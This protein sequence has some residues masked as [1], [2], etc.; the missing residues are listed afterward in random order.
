MTCHTQ[1]EVIQYGE[2]SAAREALGRL[3]ES[4]LPCLFAQLLGM[5]LG[6][7]E[8]KEALGDFLADRLARIEIYRTFTTR[9]GR[10]RSWLHTV[11]RNYVCNRLTS[12]K[13]Q[14]NDPGVLYDVDDGPDA[15]GD[16]AD[17]SDLV[18]ALEILHRAGQLMRQRC[19]G[20]SRERTWRVLEATFLRSGGGQMTRGE[21]IE[22]SGELGITV[23][24]LS[25]ART[26]ARRM[27]ADCLRDVVRQYEPEEGVD[28]ELTE[29][30][31]VLRQ[32]PEWIEK[33]RREMRLDED[34]P[35]SADPFVRLG[36]TDLRSLLDPRWR[37]GEVLTAEELR[38]VLT[39]FLQI[40]FQMD[41]RDLPAEERARAR[42]VNESADPPART[43]RA[44]LLH[45][46]PPLVSLRLIKEY[47][48]AQRLHPA[49]GI[50]PEI[51]D[52]L[53]LAAVS[54][55]LARHGTSIS[56]A[57]VGDLRI[58]LRKA[59]ASDWLDE[60]VRGLLVD[61]LQCLSASDEGG[62]AS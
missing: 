53:Y 38:S 54:A 36:P 19:I 31:A 6:R 55:A 29:L 13:L 44:V 45:A 16:E 12:A 9:Q 47:F 56:S 22:A 11:L 58:G 62:A 50:P 51:C 5:G 32:H 25:R 24:M 21:R 49:S 26:E 35:E 57:S 17:V 40:D 41:L 14:K 48:K 2:S 60:P 30:R 34:R 27:F 10:F 39:H 3:V 23:T 8:A 1:I 37:S 20:D 52:A 4:Y 15:P 46:R 59:L 28:A 42:V 43:V 18:W 33:L 61:G 7:Q